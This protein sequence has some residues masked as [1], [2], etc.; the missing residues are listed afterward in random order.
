MLSKCANPSCQAP[1]QYLSEGKLFRFDRQRIHK[2][3]PHLVTEK[4]PARRLEHFWLCSDCANHMT[5]TWDGDQGVHVQP[6][7]PYLVARA[8]AS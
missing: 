2:A 5:V 6:L 8:A 1:F 3:T 7:R 4:K